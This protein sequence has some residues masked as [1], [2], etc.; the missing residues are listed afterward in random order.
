MGPVYMELWYWIPPYATN[1][2][3][4]AHY[5]AKGPEAADALDMHWNIAQFL[6]ESLR[7]HFEVLV[8]EFETPD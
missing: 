5:E 3:A 7:E 2:L 1:A 4:V 8:G 6:P